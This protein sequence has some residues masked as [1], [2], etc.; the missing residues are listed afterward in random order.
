MKIN[1]FTA[2]KYCCI[3][4]GRVCVMCVCSS[5]WSVTGFLRMLF[6]KVM[7]VISNQWVG[8]KEI[9]KNIQKYMK[10]CC[11]DDLRLKTTKFG[12]F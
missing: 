8:F 6:K 10:S 3:L 2:V 7:T 12:I 1:I 5:H 4:H 11:F 9:V